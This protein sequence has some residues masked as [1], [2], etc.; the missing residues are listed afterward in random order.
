MNTPSQNPKRPATNAAPVSL[1]FFGAGF[2][3]L[4]AGLVVL[5]IQPDILFGDPYRSEVLSV[6]HLLLL[7]FVGSLVFGAGYMIL[8]VMAGARLWS[9]KMAWG[10]LLVHVLGTVW[11]VGAF[12]DLNFAH[13]GKAGVLVFAGMMAFVLNLTVTASKYN[14]WDPA[15]M[16]FVSALFWLCVTSGLALLML[17]NKFTPVFAAD[18]QWLMGIHAHMGL[19][20]FYWL[21]LLGASLK[22]FSMFLVSDVTPGTCSWIGL[23]LVNLALLMMI[24]TENYG[25]GDYRMLIAWVL[26][27]GS[28]CYLIDIIRLFATSR[29]RP[30][31][32]VVTAAAGILTGFALIA[33]YAAGMPVAIAEFE[34]GIRGKT[35]IYFTLAI[36]GPLLLAILG[37]GTR[38]IP[39]LVWQMR[40]ASRVGIKAVPSV[41]DLVNP[42]GKLAMCLCLL[43]G[44]GYLAAAQ[45]ADFQAGAQLGLLC[46]AIGL[47]WFFYTLMP[48][49]KLV[50][51]NIPIKTRAGA[52]PS[53][54]ERPAPPSFGADT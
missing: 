30:D 14:R 28:L 36:F 41:N 25:G 53:V 48:A 1:F 54:G 17:V 3:A 11:M 21:L 50:L 33:W 13:A 23:G 12:I 37:V 34:E 27:T 29:Q 35:R 16:S 32:G 24:P 15:L 44:W 40:Y 26:M 8:P 4:L 42:A 38:M 20:G 43:L 6:S 18:S 51:L 39:F 10:H 45:L 52:V 7:G 9:R 31:A 2:I 47:G 49:I 5:L 19:L 46:L 22:L